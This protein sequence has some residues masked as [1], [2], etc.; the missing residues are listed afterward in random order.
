[1][2]ICIPSL[3]RIFVLIHWLPLSLWARSD[4]S[5]CFF[6][7]LEAFSHED[8]NRRRRFLSSS[9]TRSLL[10]ILV[11]Y[12]LPLYQSP[13]L[14][15]SISF[16]S[17]PL[18]DDRTASPSVHYDYVNS[19]S[20]SF[21]VAAQSFWF[22]F[23]F[24]PESSICFLTWRE[25]RKQE[26]Q[27]YHWGHTK[28]TYTRRGRD[29]VSLPLQPSVGPSTQCTDRRWRSRREGQQHFFFFSVGISASR[30]SYYTPVTVSSRSK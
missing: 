30:S 9:V 22:F 13:S 8:T 16:R 19:F 14:L 15:L 24:V 28:C 2:R 11:V 10:I 5:P 20:S 17:S 7:S 18:Y 23:F 29:R 4:S 6:L 27:Q 12:V 21:C 1:M 3:H 25:Y 26:R